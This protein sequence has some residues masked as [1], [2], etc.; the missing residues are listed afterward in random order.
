M[1]DL[2]S[3][4]G[5]FVKISGRYQLSNESLINIGDSYIVVSMMSNLKEDTNSKQQTKPSSQDFTLNIRI[6][7]GKNCYEPIDF[8]PTKKS[9]TF[10]RSSKCDVVINDTILSRIQ[11]TIIYTDDEG[12]MIM[13]G[14]PKNPNNI[15]GEFESS[16][17]GTWVYLSRDTQVFDG[18]ILKTNHT[19]F[20]CSLV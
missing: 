1:K 3:G 10:G 20:Q 15:T 19:L 14:H 6:F 12:W 5:T 13:D 2:E 11:C 9:I 16:T 18:M 4:Y 8:I 7:S 17:N